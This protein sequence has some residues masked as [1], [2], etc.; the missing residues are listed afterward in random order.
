[1]VDVKICYKSYWNLHMII[2]TIQHPKTK[3]DL[4]SIP[5]WV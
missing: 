4:T 2:L 5:F 1:M 3:L